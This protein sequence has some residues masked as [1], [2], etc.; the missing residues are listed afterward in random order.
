MKL[1]GSLHLQ[2]TDC[3]RCQFCKTEI[4]NGCSHVDCS[5]LQ[6]I[7][8]MVAQL[9]HNLQY[10]T[11]G[12]V[13][14]QKSVSLFGYIDVGD[15]ICRWRLWP[16]LSSTYHL[17]FPIFQM[18]LKCCPMSRV[19]LIQFSWQ[20]ITMCP[21]VELVVNLLSTTATNLTLE[22]VKKT[23]LYATVSKFIEKHIIWIHFKDKGVNCDKC[24]RCS[25]CFTCSACISRTCPI[26][27]HCKARFEDLIAAL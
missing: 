1:S 27:S 25:H 5:S 22:H 13:N 19:V 11:A 20:K 4:L 9:E 16:F 18:N 21:A 7:E 26:F 2:A 10:F 17:V 23:A 14:I 15:E 8:P 3:N 6:N 12:T 24:A